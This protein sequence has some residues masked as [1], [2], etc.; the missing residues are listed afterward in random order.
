MS[1]AAPVAALS[2][3][4]VHLTPTVPS[5]TFVGV[6]S[7]QGRGRGVG[8]G[9]RV[10]HGADL[11]AGSEV[12]RLVEVGVRG[13]RGDAH[14]RQVGAVSP[15]QPRRSGVL[16]KPVWQE[17]WK[18]P[19]TLTHWPWGHRPSLREHSS[20]SAGKHMADWDA[21]CTDG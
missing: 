7:G 5:E 4:A 15:T 2:V 17:H 3:N 12:R 8:L 6:C 10:K 18:E 21:A 19:M 16:W 1:T 13:W 20:M 9:D 14:V 11:G